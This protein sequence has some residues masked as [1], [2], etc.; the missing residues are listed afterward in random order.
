MSELTAQ[1][2]EPAP[3]VS[4]ALR[5]L[6][7]EIAELC[8]ADVEP[9]V[10]HADFL[11]R[12]IAGL[13][14]H[15]G[16]VWWQVARGG[17]ELQGQLGYQSVL[18]LSDA[19]DRQQHDGLLAQVAELGQ[20]LLASPHTTLEGSP[21]AANPSDFALL[22]CP[23]EVEGEVLGIVEVVQ[24]PGS[25]SSAQAGYLRF[26]GQLCALA[27]GYHARRRGRQILEQQRGWSRYDQFVRLAH[28]SLELP[29][30]AYT[31]A[32]EGC[33]WI[34][35]D[36]LSV[37]VSR[38]RKCRI[39]A[40][41]GEDSVNQRSN[42]IRMLNR[43]AAAVAK[44]GEPLWYRGDATTLPPQI[45]QLLQPYVDQSHAKCLAVLPLM[46]APNDDPAAAPT[47]RSEVIGTLIVEQF[48]TGT[49]DDAIRERTQ[50]VARHATLALGN[51]LQYNALFLLP[52]WRALGKASWIVRS[53]NLPKVLLA[54][55]LLAG[56]VLALV[57]IPADFDLE[58]RG[59]LE[60]ET[61]RDIYVPMDGLIEEVLVTHGQQVGQGATL[62]QLRNPQH[63]YQQATV[64][65]E[66]QTVIRQLAASK[67]SL[68]TV[69]RQ[70]PDGRARHTQLAAEVEELSIRQQNLE[71]QHK[72]LA[73]QAKDLKIISPIAGQVTTWNVTD[74][75]A[76][77]PV[78]RGQAL[79]RVADTAG[80]WTLELNLPDRR[81]GHVRAAQQAL[82]TDLPVSFILA[83]DP[84]AT[85]QGRLRE[86]AMSAEVD[87]EHGS[88][89]RVIAAA[90]PGQTS[91]LRPGASVVA[92]IHCGRRSLG[93][94]WFHE[95][96]E[97]VQSRV[98]F[99]L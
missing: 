16:A 47:A 80:P 22:L 4:Q 48:T 79:L 95:L 9:A 31:L 2:T 37:A 35:C 87:E 13:G 3:N 32:N 14:A 88:A 90:E 91:D 7:N 98:L 20:P 5:A 71:A 53:R 30:V 61:R 10:F 6:V 68:L 15:A 11:E 64:L 86:V 27:G 92:K 18:P 29:L 45:E 74:L 94:V 77:R 89:V 93:Y 49:F 23:L 62:V 34:G 21:H 40:V 83:S 60:P 81:A 50:T 19:H 26:L 85:Y 58:V 96:I 44:S 72:L 57:L 99:K 28:G 52:L 56:I 55:L 43:L 8:Q 42:T 41:S 12:A 78:Q 54:T 70:S 36:R 69:D 97:F 38:G 65:G 46:A 33:R 82:Q 73:E 17:F 66:L 24:R 84:S 39:E 63:E 1:S 59:R 51:A 25:T 76:D 67:A 75:L